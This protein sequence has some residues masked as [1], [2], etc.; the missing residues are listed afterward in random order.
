[1]AI[2]DRLVGDQANDSAEANVVSAVIPGKVLIDGVDGDNSRNPG[3]GPER[4]IETAEPLVVAGQNAGVLCAGAR[5][6]VAEGAHQVRLEN[7]RPAAGNAFAVGQ[8]DGI[9]RESGELRRIAGAVV[10]AVVL[11]VAASEQCVLVRQAEI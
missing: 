9:G 4:S 10:R 3:A 8:T 2:A 1:M 11:E 5:Q 6:T 7:G